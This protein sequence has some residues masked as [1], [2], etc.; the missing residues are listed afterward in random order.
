MASRQFTAL[1]MTWKR[2]LAGCWPRI[3]RTKN[4]LQRCGAKAVT[5]RRRRIDESNSTQRSIE[6]FNFLD[7]VRWNLRQ[8]IAV[9]RVDF[10]HRRCAFFAEA[11]VGI[12]AISSFCPGGEIHDADPYAG[13]RSSGYVIAVPIAVAH[14]P[15][16]CHL[17]Q[18]RTQRVCG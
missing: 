3:I 16:P 12:V 18:A 1:N 7:I 15:V 9:S 11:Y 10:F 17:I 14:L 13:K 4:G 8:D 5:C 6:R 2:K